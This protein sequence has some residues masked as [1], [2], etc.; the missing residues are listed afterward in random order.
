MGPVSQD[1][2]RKPDV[3]PKT[4][5]DPVKGYQRTFAATGP[6]GMTLNSHD[7]WV[8]RCETS[9]IEGET[10]AMADGQYPQISVF[11]KT[12]GIRQ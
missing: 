7:L 9:R 1:G 3:M 5:L 8:S 4:I 11:S 2:S 12:L 10:V 6:N